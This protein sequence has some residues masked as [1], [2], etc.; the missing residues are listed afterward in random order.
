MSL[1]GTAPGVDATS[2]AKVIIP[3]LSESVSIVTKTEYNIVVAAT[4]NGTGNT[5]V[6]PSA[7]APMTQVLS[8]RKEPANYWTGGGSGYQFV[9][10]LASATS[11]FT[12]ASTTAATT[13]AASF[14]VAIPTLSWD[15]DGNTAGAGGATPDGAWNATTANW[16]A[17]YLGTGDAATWTN[18]MA[19]AFAA[20]T[21]ATGAYTVTVDGTQDIGSLAFEEGEVTL[22]GGTAL[23]VSGFAIVNAASG[24]SATI[25]TP[26]SEDA[27]GRRLTKTGSG[28]V[29]LA[30]NNTY[31][32]DTAV[33]PAGGTL[34]LAGNNTA[35][36]GGM[37]LNGGVTRFESPASIN[38]TARSIAVNA[39]GAVAFGP[40][41]GAVNIP[42]ALSGRIAAASAGAIAADNYDTLN[43]DFN[44]PGLTAASLGAAGNVTYTGTLTPSGTTY[45]L[46]GGGGTL[47]MTNANALT[48]PGKS[49]VINGDV[50]LPSANDFD[51]GTTL[52]TGVLAIGNNNCLGSGS[53][54]VNGGGI[55]SDSAT[56]HTLANATTI[57]ADVTLGNTVNNGKLTFTGP[58]GLGTVNRVITLNSEAELAG[59]ISGAAGALT[60]TGTNTLT[61][62]G[63]NTYSGTTTVSQGTLVLAGSNSS[64]GTTLLSEGTTLQLG[65]S[66]NGGLASGTLTFGALNATVLQPIGADR[67]IT[68]AVS[69]T[70]I[71]SVGG[72]AIIS[73]SQNLEISGIFTF[74]SGGGGNR[75]LTS[76]LDSGKALTL[77]GQVKLTDGTAA[78]N[79][80]IDGTGT[81]RITG[82]AVNGGTGAGSLTKGG[83]GLL[84]LSNTNTYTGATSVTGGTLAVSGTGA[85]NTSSGITINGATAAFMHNS[86]V[87]NTRAFTLTRG[88][89]GGAGTI[90]TALT[91]G[92]NVIIAPGDRTLA[93]PAKGTL[94]VTNGVTLNAGSATALRLFGPTTNDSDKLVQSTTGTIA[95]GGVLSVSINGS[96][97]PVAGTT[98]DLFDWIGTPTGTFSSFSLPAL[99]TGFKWHDYGSGVFFDYTTGQ[100][101]IDADNTPP[102]L[103]GSNIVDDQIG[104]PI[105]ENTLVT[106]TVTFSEDMD[107]ATVTAADFGNAGTS[108]IS[109]GT[110]TEITPGVFTVQVTPTS[111][112]SLQLKINAGAQLMDHAGNLLNT[113]SAIVD[114]T[115]LVVTD[116]TPPTLA[117]TNIVDNKSGGPVTAYTLVTYTVTFNER[118]NSG[119]VS[120]DDFSNAGSS[121]ITF[122]TITQASPG[123]FTV[124]ITPTTVGTLI[125]QV[126]AGAVITDV[127]GNALDT[128]VAIV[129]ETT[130]TVDAAA[131]YTSWAANNAPTGT[132]VDDYDGDGVRNGVEYVLGG[133]K[134]SNDL[135]KLPKVA[136]SGGNLIFSFERKQA[137]IDG[138]TTLVIE[139]GT[140]L[141]AWPGSYPVPDGAVV[142]N[143]GLTVTKD[144]PTVGTDTVTLTLPQ[145]AG[146]TK[147]VRLKVTVM[148]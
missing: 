98:Y 132:A 85:I 115:I 99:A 73:G 26:L 61:L 44:T 77:S 33:S 60:K 54:I 134:E 87:A 67:K 25:E 90:S 64:T 3:T 27:A 23:R 41:F 13:I 148:P 1:V 104:V 139:T 105:A 7:Q 125:L 76:S 106:Y 10:G 56:A 92:A 117:G 111:G 17:N 86:S 72:T 68:S 71:A 12:S 30:G 101:R 143:P 110:I 84:V 79:Q 107:A 94:T 65:G 131:G 127:A 118:I 18:G 100:I 147:F 128:T 146:A 5:G 93:A 113:T 45:R 21:D 14:G 145:A 20:G 81:T 103:A 102:T 48:G 70:Y 40:S 4:E 122:G 55:A 121:S 43:F 140:T 78:R 124:P 59:S 97:A 39:G 137:A 38:G 49:L 135:G 138:T 37:S 75:T 32:G 19:A 35:A 66:V 6:K 57:A 130:I 2:S 112:T 15:I 96:L 95:F 24:L 63:A 74:A 83:T 142:A 9:K 36:T 120:T 31:T 52:N 133:T 29:V 69:L 80:T 109:I 114:D 91:A 123:V 136:T 58:A 11:T 22:T 46:G 50:T 116:T 119:T 53:L 16:N 51:A 144:L 82:Q 88:T 129:D 89:L 28:T 62:S 126:N 108:G 47:T 34:V 8:F 141:A 42:T